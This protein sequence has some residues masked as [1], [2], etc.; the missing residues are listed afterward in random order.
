[1]EQWEEENRVVSEEFVQREEKNWVVSK[2]DETT[3]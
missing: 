2:G 3:S 1:M